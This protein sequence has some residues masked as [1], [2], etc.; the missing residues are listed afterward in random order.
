MTNSKGRPIRRAITR[1]SSS[2]AS[3]PIPTPE[4]STRRSR[5]RNASLRA[6]ATVF[7][8]DT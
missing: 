8:F 2:A 4:K 3:R 7:A 6:A 5:A 1:L